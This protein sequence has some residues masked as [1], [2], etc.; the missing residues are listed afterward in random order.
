MTNVSAWVA[1]Q[2]FHSYVAYMRSLCCKGSKPHKQSKFEYNH[3]NVSILSCI[4]SLE[5]LFNLYGCGWIWLA[6]LFFKG[7]VHKENKSVN[8][9][10][11]FSFNFNLR[12]TCW[13]PQPTP[14]KKNRNYGQPHSNIAQINVTLV[15]I[16]V[17]YTFNIYERKEK[18]FHRIARTR[19]VV[20]RY[21]WQ[22]KNDLWEINPQHVP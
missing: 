1:P 12:Q 7:Y 11:Q 14:K 3:E 20:G 21:T 10:K 8:R 5:T 4:N 13:M 16:L 9:T 15:R 2:N 18:L 19:N 22:R 17:P 6:L